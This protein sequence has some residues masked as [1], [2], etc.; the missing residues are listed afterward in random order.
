MTTGKTKNLTRQTFVGK[1]ISLLFNMLSRLVI[2]FLPRN[3]RL[4]ISWL[5]SP[6]AVILEPP[7]N[8]VCHCFHCFPYYLPW[9]DRTR[10]HD[11]SFPNFGCWVL[12]QLFQC[13][14]GDPGSIPGLG[15]SPGKGSGNPLQ[16]SS[17]ENPMDREAWLVSVP[18]VT[19]LNMTARLT[20]SMYLM[21]SIFPSLNS[22]EGT[23]LVTFSFA[24]MS[25]HNPWLQCP[26]TS[27]PPWSC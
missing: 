24:A 7:K 6:S 3:K 18:G 20:H 21:P 8:K 11:L 12:S 26:G 1:V 27:H 23:S 16:Y 4:L 10:C 13:N 14:A 9:S 17:L 15:R 2:G 19:E 25:H 5:R 22:Q